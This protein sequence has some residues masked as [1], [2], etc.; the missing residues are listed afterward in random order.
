MNEYLESPPAQEL[1]S[2]AGVN[3]VNNMER[4]ID[5]VES[6]PRRPV[7]PLLG[8]PGAHITRTSIKQNMFNWGV[9]F[10]SLSTL[11]QEFKPDAML[12]MMDL[13]VEA[14]ALGLPV[15]FP[16]QGAATIE[17]HPVRS[18]QDLMAFAHLD[19]LQDA[20]ANV[21]IQ[22]VDSLSKHIDVPVGAYVIGPFSLSALLMGASEA[23]IATLE[24]INF[25]QEVLSFSSRVIGRYASALIEAGASFVVVLDPTAVLLSP[26]QFRRFCVPHMRVLQ[27]RLEVPIVLHICGNTTHLIEMMADCQV[28]GL[29]LDSMVDLRAAADKI[30]REV[31]LIGNTNPTAVLSSGT[32]SLVRKETATLIESMAGVQNFIVSTGCDIPPETPIANI[33]AFMEA[34]RE[35]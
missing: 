24:D 15:R 32:P 20:R 7:I 8:F 6:L 4:L 30:P 21:F 31:V 23:A 19:I 22:T 33:H 26:K 12:C 2:W 13:S 5:W 35:T 25:V 16:L 17:E 29:S 18:V 11:Y 10:W 14:G 28:D 3:G 1:N 9:Q 27:E 34:G